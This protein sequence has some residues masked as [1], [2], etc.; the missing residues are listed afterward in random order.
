MDA[1]LADQIVLIA[2]PIYA[3]MIQ[4]QLSIEGLHAP[5][6]MLVELRRQALE[7]ALALRQEA[8]KMPGRGDHVR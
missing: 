4:H 6:A 7:E 5:V 1:E 2:A 3:A 8:L